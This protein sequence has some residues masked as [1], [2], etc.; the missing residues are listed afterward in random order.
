MR[1]CLSLFEYVSDMSMEVWLGICATMCVLKMRVASE[2]DFVFKS[3]GISHSVENN[4]NCFGLITM[5]NCWN[6]NMNMIVTLNNMCSLMGLD[7]LD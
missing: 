1:I 4:G 6:I 5:W 7:I 3:L 2:S